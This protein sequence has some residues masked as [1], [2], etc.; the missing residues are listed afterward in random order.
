MLLVIAAVSLGLLVVAWIAYPALMWLRA[1]RWQ[2]VGKLALAPTARVAAV[3]ATR[4]DPAFAAARVGN[5]RLSHYPPELLQVVVAVDA[6][7]AASDDAY[8]AALPATTVVRGEA[9]GGKALALNAGVAAASGCNILLFADVGQEFDEQTIGLLVA[10]IEA[11]AAGAT[12]RYTHHR[13][14]EV[15]SAWADF[16]AVIRAG[17]AAGRGVVSATGA[18]FAI[19]RE[20][21][22]DLPAG[23]ICDDLY[24]GLS[25]ALQRGRLTFAPRAVA[26]DPRT[27][28]RDQQFARRARTLTGLIQYCALEPAVLVPWRNPLWLHF[29]VHKLLRLLTPV[30]LGAS[31]VAL[32]TQVLLFGPSSLRMASTGALIFGVGTVALAAAASRRFRDQVLWIARLQLV[33]VIAILNGLRGR[34]AVWTPTPQGRT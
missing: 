11:G 16:E 15:M 28:T 5:L 21:W 22:R 2:P 19:R 7:A 4:D 1:R 20:F 25:V 6:N 26:F 8:R 30:L 34:W 33:P 32:T 31:L 10:A 17:Q 14:D 12:G 23:T 18:V 27:F 24:T 29:I 9:P 3:I 13:D